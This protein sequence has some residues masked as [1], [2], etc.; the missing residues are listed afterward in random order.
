MIA[1]SLSED[2]PFQIKERVFNEINLDDLRKEN[3]LE[4]LLQFMSA[5]L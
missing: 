4:I 5:H 1:L 3:G 2:D